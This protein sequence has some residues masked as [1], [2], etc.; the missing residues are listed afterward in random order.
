MTGVCFSGM[1][2]GNARKPHWR[3]PEKLADQCHRVRSELSAAG[4]G[5][6][7]CGAFKR[8]ELSVSHSTACVLADGFEDVL[9]R[10]GMALEL[11]RRDRAAIENETWNIQAS[12]GHHAA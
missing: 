1:R 4:A 12:Q 10:D 11:A 9:D 3:N 8:L 7:A 6:G 5:P 2:G